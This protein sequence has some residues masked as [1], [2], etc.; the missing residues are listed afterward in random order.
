MEIDFQFAGLCS[1][2]YK[3]PLTWRQMTRERELVMKRLVW[4]MIVLLSLGGCGAGFAEKASEKVSKPLAYSGYSAAEYAGHTGFSAY[5]PVPD[6]V[7]LAVDVFLPAQGHERDAFPV[8]LFYTPYQRSEI[9]PNTGK[10][11]DVTT[12]S[13]GPFFLSFGYAIVYADMRGTGASTGWPCHRSRDRA[14]PQPTR[15]RW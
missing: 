4:C 10:V 15:A 1:K 5:V 3:T 11:R 6:G 14:A 2:P 7:K 8:I 13:I 12:Q 9:D